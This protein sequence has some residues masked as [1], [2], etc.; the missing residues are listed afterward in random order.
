MDIEHDGS[1]TYNPNFN[2]EWA[3][4]GMN[5][6]ANWLNQLP[7]A[8]GCPDWEKL[9]KSR[10]DAR[11]GAFFYRHGGKQALLGNTKKAR[12]IARNLDKCGY[13]WKAQKIHFTA[14]TLGLIG[15]PWLF[16]LANLVFTN[17]ASKLTKI[18]PKE[19]AVIEPQIADL[20]P[21]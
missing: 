1:I 13:R 10:I 16:R 8:K 11:I 18:D 19:Y 17:I 20:L 14:S 3:W 2:D 9:I 12:R 6:Y 7:I 4:L 5:D 15:G 21:Q